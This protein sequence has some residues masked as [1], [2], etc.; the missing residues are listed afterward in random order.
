MYKNLAV[1]WVGP[2]GVGSVIG[3]VLPALIKLARRGSIEYGAPEILPVS[4]DFLF[5]AHVNVKC[6]LHFKSTEGAAED[7]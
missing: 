4:K 2:N 6:R 1:C 7:E 3:K 5:F